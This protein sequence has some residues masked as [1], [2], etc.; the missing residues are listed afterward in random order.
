MSTHIIHA[1]PEIIPERNDEW[2][3]LLSKTRK[4]RSAN[5]PS[6]KLNGRSLEG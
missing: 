4:W 2:D 1:Y 5:K 6:D 3:G